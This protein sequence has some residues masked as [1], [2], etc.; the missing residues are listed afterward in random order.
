MS[1]DHHFHNGCLSHSPKFNDK[2]MRAT[3]W[4]NVCLTISNAL[5]VLWLSL[6]RF[7]MIDLLQKN[8]SHRRPIQNSK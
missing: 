2:L 7:P 8:I 4:I 3:E 1:E 5:L 6:Q